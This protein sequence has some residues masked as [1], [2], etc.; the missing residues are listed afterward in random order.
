MVQLAGAFLDPLWRLLNVPIRWISDGTVEPEL[1]RPLEY[2]ELVFFGL[3]LGLIVVT[4]WDAS[5]KRVR[6][7][8]RRAL[9]EQWRRRLKARRHQ[10]RFASEGRN[11]GHLGPSR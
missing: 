5:S 9:Q 6:E 7:Q 10:L 1:E 8:E 11:D 4:V 3:V 2:L